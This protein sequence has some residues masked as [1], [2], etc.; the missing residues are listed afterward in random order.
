MKSFK[1]YTVSKYS[2]KGPC[3]VY[4][5]NRLDAVRVH[6]EHLEKISYLYK[7]T[8]DIKSFKNI[9]Y[10]KGNPRNSRYYKDKN[11]NCFLV[12]PDRQK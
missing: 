4:A 9:G 1:L 11:G 2:E 7:N 5:K 6:V 12:I 10:K 8:Y 3:T